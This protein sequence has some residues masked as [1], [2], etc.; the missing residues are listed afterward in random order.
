MT[1]SI[2]KWEKNI[3]KGSEVLVKSKEDVICCLQSL[4]GENV[5]QL[6]A[7]GKDGALL[8]GGGADNFIVTY[9]LGNNTEFYNLINEEFINSNEDVEVVTGGQA[10]IFPKSMVVD[11]E[12][13]LSSLLYFFSFQECNPELIW[14]NE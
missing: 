12:T 6:V 10:G 11:F 14:D 8:I 1:F 2:D 7:N 13:A 5:T 9:I 3:N 4:N